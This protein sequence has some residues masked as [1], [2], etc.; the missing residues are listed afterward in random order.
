MRFC[1]VGTGRCGSTMLRDLLALHPDG[2]VF[3]ETHWIPILWERCGERPVR[4]DR[5]LEVVQRTRFVDGSKVTEVDEEALLRRFAA[6][7]RE[8]IGIREFC[9]LLATHLAGREISWWADKTPDYGPYMGL[10]QQL[11]PDCRFVDLVRQP[12]DVV[13]S[14][15]RHPGYRWLA[16]AR[17]LSW[18]SAALDHEPEETPADIPLEEFV[19]LWRERS[20]RTADEAARLAPGSFR[21]ICYESFLRDPTQSLREVAEFLEIDPEPAWIRRAARRVRRAGRGAPAR[22]ITDAFAESDWRLAEQLGYPRS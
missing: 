10:L 4:L 12:W 7:G 13:A 9:A 14:M 11:W 8:V 6:D 20:L 1:I 19:S 18:V 3:R 15:S 5:L 17:R 22:Q 16:A 21:R 2:F